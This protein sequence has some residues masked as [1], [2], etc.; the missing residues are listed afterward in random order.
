MI[1]RDHPDIENALRTGYPVGGEPELTYCEF[2]EKEI[3]DDTDCYE[4]EDYHVLCRRCLL[5][6]HKKRW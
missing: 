1:L 4:D 2:C 5:K 3:Q 6:L